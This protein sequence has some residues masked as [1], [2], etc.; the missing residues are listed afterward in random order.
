M[1]VQN[2]ILKLIEGES[3]RINLAN[4]ELPPLP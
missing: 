2:G 1:R 4:L 3:P